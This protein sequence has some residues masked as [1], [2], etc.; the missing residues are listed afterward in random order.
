MA[1]NFRSNRKDKIPIEQ[2]YFLKDL[3]LYYFNILRPCNYLLNKWL[4]I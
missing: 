1:E 4:Q 2:T 3:L